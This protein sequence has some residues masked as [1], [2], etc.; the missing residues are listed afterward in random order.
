MLLT[1]DGNLAPSWLSGKSV[2]PLT[3][4][5]RLGAIL[6]DRVMAGCR[7]TGATHLRYAPLGADPIVTTSAIPAD[8]TTR[9]STLLWTPDH[10]GALLF[11][12]PGHVLLAGTK[13][14][15]TAAVPEGTDAARAR[16]TR[17]ACKQAARH[18]ELLAVAATYVPT[19]HAWS[20]A[21]EVPPDT[22]TAHHLNLLRE[23]S[24]GTLPA[25]TFAYAWWQTRRTAKSNGER[26]RGPLEE[27]FNHVF[28]LL[29]DYEVAPE[30]AEPTDLTA[31]ELQAAVTE[32]YRDTQAPALI[33]SE[34]AA[35]AAPGQG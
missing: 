12:A 30:L 8:V 11:P 28:L 29:E 34:G 16:F 31:P 24:N 25:P 9:P 7:S 20:D 14:F 23:F 21:A 26:V 33:P 10:Q 4:G 6:A 2:T 35:S 17:Y 1:L 27:L 15:M 19:H 18:P 5:E 22:A 13:P 3:A 32:A